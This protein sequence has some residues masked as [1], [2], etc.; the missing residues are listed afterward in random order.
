MR[1]LFCLIAIAAL[2][3][4]CSDDDPVQPVVHQYDRTVLVYMSGEN[5]LTSYIKIG[6]EG[7]RAG[8]A[9]IGNNALVVYVDDANKNRNPY[10]IRIENGETKDSFALPND[11]LSSDPSAF[12]DVLNYT[13]THFPANDY[14]LVLWGHATGWL[15]EDSVAVS[16]S[17]PFRA[18]GGDNGQNTSSIR[19]L[20]WMNMPTM[21]QTLTQWGKPLKF[22]LADCCQFQCVEAA[23][24]L[25]NCVD[26]IIASPAEIP[27]V[28]C[29]YSTVTKHFFSHS[30]DFYK[31]IVDRYYEQV[32]PVYYR[33]DWG[34]SITYDSRTPLSVV[35]TS[36]LESLASAT[37]YALKSMD[38]MRYEKLPALHKEKLIYYYGNVDD[39]KESCMYDMNDVMLH[40]AD[41]ATY[42]S[43]KKAFD[44]A[45][46]YKVNAKEGW[47]TAQ[48]ILPY[49]FGKTSNDEKITQVLTDERYGGVSMFVPQKSSGTWY[50]PYTNINGNSMNGYNAD[51]KKTAWYHAVKLSDLGW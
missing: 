3:S 42:D 12:R 23:Y 11:P 18:F 34:F 27:G 21:A 30:A 1:K 6:L 13:S 8:S 47:M 4:S 49:V 46:V 31:D 36:E 26:Y 2:L 43:W 44:K 45:V 33:K 5:N 9:N 35:K 39:I 7:L 22:I 20:V 28:G 40:F 32:I 51:I 24:E 48:Q 19:G 15:F 37:S 29:P 10:I 41:S 16:S 17:R 14:G 38:T 25:R 50:F